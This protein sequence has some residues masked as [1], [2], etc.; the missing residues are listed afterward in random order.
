M[1]NKIK[2]HDVEVELKLQKEIPAIYCDVKQI[3]QT[4]LAIIINAVEAMERGGKLCIQSQTIEGNQVRVS[5]ADTGAGIS[6]EH[7]KNI[8]DPFFTTKEL[9]KSTGLGLFVAYGIINEHKG[10]IEVESELGHG[11]TFHIQFPVKSL[12]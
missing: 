11:T 9:A 8:F 3:Q 5:I 1:E 12:V 7:L 4:L 10:T 2:L 6:E